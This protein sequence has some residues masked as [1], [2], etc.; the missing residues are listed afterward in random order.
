MG[1]N[2]FDRELVLRFAAVS[3]NMAFATN[4][5]M[6]S[7]NKVSGGALE[8]WQKTAK[9]DGSVSNSS[10]TTT[11]RG[12]SV[13]DESEANKARNDG[14]GSSNDSGS[15]VKA[16]KE[17]TQDESCSSGSRS[18]QA[19]CEDS[20][21]QPKQQNSLKTAGPMESIGSVGHPDN[22]KPCAFYCFSLCGCRMD[23]DCAYCHL[24]HQ[25]RLKQRREDWKR[26]Q[27][28]RRNKQRP[29]K[30]SSEAVAASSLTPGVLATPAAPGLMP[31]ST[32]QGTP[33]PVP[34]MSNEGSGA[35]PVGLLTPLLNASPN[36][37]TPY[38]G[39]EV[40]GTCGL[41]MGASPALATGYAED[42][43]SQ[44]EDTLEGLIQQVSM[45]TA[46]LRSLLPMLSGVSNANRVA[47][48]FAGHQ[49]E[50]LNSHGAYATNGQMP[51]NNIH[52]PHSLQDNLT[53]LLH[54]GVIEMFEYVPN[55]LEVFVG[56]MLELWPPVSQMRGCLFAVAPRLPAGV[57]LDERSGL[58]HG[59]PQERTPGQVTYFITACNPQ[60]SP[61][62][63]NV[64][65][66][67]LTV[68]HAFDQM[69]L[70]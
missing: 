51:V 37:A 54:Q 55:S 24:F 66:V 34:E 35:L 69:L 33:Y 6:R 18:E 16:Y 10:S 14:S 28:V 32:A 68:N 26:A 7:L 29:S 44:G 53:D 36:E 13:Y 5:P 59:R 21:E 56:Q 50:V 15:T 20:S 27:R 23:R 12:S 61:T 62:M 8:E 1:G 52:P 9:E 63:V 67:K 45:N 4:K 48:L 25:S 41:S 58:L 38:V 47:S 31:M 57:M 46:L 11:G 60:R 43:A 49:A 65:L 40:P 3:T 42:G 30:T 19:Q 17:S 22:C 2:S 64:A 39:P 70:C